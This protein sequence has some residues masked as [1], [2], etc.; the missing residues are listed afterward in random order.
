[1]SRQVGTLHIVPDHNNLKQPE[2]ICD[3]MRQEISYLANSRCLI[4]LRRSDLEVPDED[5]V[6]EAD[7]PSVVNQKSSSPVEVSVNVLRSCSNAGS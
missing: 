7:C 3:Y 6:S 1:M 4:R 2:S 5:P